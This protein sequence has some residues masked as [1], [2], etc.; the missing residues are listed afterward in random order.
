MVTEKLLT[1]MVTL[2]VEYDGTR[3]H[4][5]QLQT[6]QPTIQGEIEQA[7]EKLTGERI[8][9]V[10]ASRTDAGV[11][12]KGQVIGFRTK[13]ALSTD[14]FVSGLNYYLPD[15]ISI[16]SSYEMTN[17][18]GIRRE[19]ISREYRYTILNRSTQSPLERYQAYWV[20]RSLDIVAMSSACHFLIGKH[21]F[22]SFTKKDH[23]GN[24]VR[25]VFKAEMRREKDFVFFDIV[26]DSFLQQQV[27]RTVG[28]LVEVGTDRI[29]VQTF[30][31]LVDS[32]I[33]GKARP[34][35]P[36]HGLCLT[37]VNYAD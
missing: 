15:A 11:H 31:D 30:K 20:A 27:R 18:F 22:A 16:K 9:I 6:Q 35:A 3:Y 33:F 34:T 21:D 19:A 8:R 4:G 24:T 26:A 5:F 25:T 10:G 37:A 14:R 32:P 1:R 28:A 7:L 13:S 23:T 36:A 29:N 2:I 12:A 17:N